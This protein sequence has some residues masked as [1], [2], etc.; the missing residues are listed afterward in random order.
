MKKR[1]EDRRHLVL[2]LDVLHEKHDSTLGRCVNIS[3]N[4]IMIISRED[5]DIERPMKVRLAL[6]ARAGFSDK[7]LPIILDIK[8]KKKDVNPDYLCYGALF[9]GMTKKSMEIIE[10]LSSFPAFSNNKK[11]SEITDLSEYV[12]DIDE[13]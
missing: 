7:Y 8:W 9:A 6:P 10:Q 5:I 13:E 1:T 12:I 2:Y 4:G 3:R 11:M